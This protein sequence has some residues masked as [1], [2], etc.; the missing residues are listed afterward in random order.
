VSLKTPYSGLSKIFCLVMWCYLKSVSVYG[1]YYKIVWRRLVMLL[2]W[3]RFKTHNERVNQVFSRMVE[4]ENCDLFL[5]SSSL[6]RYLIRK[7]RSKNFWEEENKKTHSS[8]RSH[9]DVLL[10]LFWSKV[11]RLL[12]LIGSYTFFKQPR[13]F[14]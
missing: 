2:M 13:V 8:R 7:V 6:C 3:D 11:Q 9:N 5:F 1:S 14:P 12:L 10:G 4:V